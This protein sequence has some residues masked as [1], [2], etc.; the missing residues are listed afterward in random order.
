MSKTN[1]ITYSQ[2]VKL[3]KLAEAEHLTTVGHF[4]LICKVALVGFC[5]IL[6]NVIKELRDA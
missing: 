4:D 5:M 3:R 2:A 1:I 6:D